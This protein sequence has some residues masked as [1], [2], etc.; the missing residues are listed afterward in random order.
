MS[1][2][3][4]KYTMRVPATPDLG[5]ATEEDG[6][7]TL[8]SPKGVLFL[9]LLSP[10]IE[11]GNARRGKELVAERLVLRGVKMEMVSAAGGN[12]FPLARDERGKLSD[13][14]SS[15]AN[16]R[17]AADAF[18]TWLYDNGFWTGAD[19]GWLMEELQAV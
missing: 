8:V 15:L 9:L 11:A 3:N 18:V 5:D 17:D 14:L 1:K 10:D 2:G 6:K 7:V 19:S 16:K 12:V 4:G 13:Y